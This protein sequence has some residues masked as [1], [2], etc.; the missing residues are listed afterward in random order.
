MNTIVERLQSRGTRLKVVVPLALLAIFL[1]LLGSSAA[2]DDAVVPT[3][4]I[5]T[6][7]FEQ[8]GHLAFVDQPERFVATVADWLAR[9]CPAEPPA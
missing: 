8:C 4:T 2:Q 1:V 7:I 6:V 9:R 5:E 3:F